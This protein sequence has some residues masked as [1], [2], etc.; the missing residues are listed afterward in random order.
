MMQLTGAESARFQQGFFSDSLVLLS[1]SVYL[2]DIERSQAAYLQ[3]AQHLVKQGNKEKAQLILNKKKL[4]EKEV[5][6]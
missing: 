4:V 2:D 6:V 5:S 3:E 1:F